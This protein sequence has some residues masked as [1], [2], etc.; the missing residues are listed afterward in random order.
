MK[1]TD[2]Y[3][4]Y[5]VCA[6]SRYTLM[7]GIHTGHFLPTQTPVL[8]K[9]SVTV[10]KVLSA[11]GYDTA[12]I[13]KWG[14]DNSSKVSPLPPSSGFPLFQ[15]FQFFQGQTDQWQVSS[16]QTQLRR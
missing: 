8:S 9:D 2:H 16:Q 10:A 5:S 13:G 3:A 12:V 4:G 14:L 11:H 6:P 7:T 15:G 1:F